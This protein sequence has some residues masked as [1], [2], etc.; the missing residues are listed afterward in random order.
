MRTLAQEL[1]TQGQFPYDLLLAVMSCP[2]HYSPQG[3]FLIFK[4]RQSILLKWGDQHDTMTT[5]HWKMLHHIEMEVLLNYVPET[6]TSGD[7]HR[8]QMICTGFFK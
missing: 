7:S 4:G 1:E 8:N 3:N 5:L 6:H 2:S